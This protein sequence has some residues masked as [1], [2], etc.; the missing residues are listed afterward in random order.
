M[1]VTPAQVYILGG[2]FAGLYTAL[3][4][5]R[6][7]WKR[8]LKPQI[9]LIDKNDRFLFTPF[10][11]EFVTQEFQQWEIAPPYLKLLVGT[12]IQFCRGTVEQVDLNN[13]Q[14]RLQAGQVLTYDRLVLAVGRETSLDIIPGAASYALPFRTLADADR[15]KAKLRSLEASEQSIIRVAIA[16]GGPSGVELAGKL[17][18]RLQERGQI[19]LIERGATLLKSFTTFSQKTAHQVLAA[20]RVRVDLET[21]IQSI[22]Y[23]SITLENQGQVKTVAVDLV[24]WTA[25]TGVNSSLRHLDCRQNPQ[26]QLLTRPT[27]QLVDYP[28]VFALGDL[29]NICDYRGKPIPATAQSAYQQASC[30]AYNLRASLTKRSLRHFHYLHLGEML[31]LGINT[32]I[33]SSLGFINLKGYIGH[34]SRQLVYLLL[35]MPTLR[36]R[37]QVGKHWLFRF[38]HIWLSGNRSKRRVSK[39]RWQSASY[40]DQESRKTVDNNSVNQHK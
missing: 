36:H 16:G 17:A 24:L 14:V 28:E 10:L 27:L 11:Y 31:T 8:S 33:V 35:R 30:A 26:G 25:G 21:N 2:G 34:I 6:F 39:N 23:D 38:F 22:G 18:D 5:D 4:L 32:A 3:Q 7:P 9:T 37:I 29:A 40:A 20:H 19:H 13:R 1:N 12:D 15:L